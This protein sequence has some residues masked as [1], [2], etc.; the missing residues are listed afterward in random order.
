MTSPLALSFYRQSTVLLPAYNEANFLGAL[1]TAL[2]S[3]SAHVLVVDDGSTDG[4]TETA[5]RHGANVVRH[6]RNRGKGA[7]LRSGIEYALAGR[8]EWIAVMD[9]DGQHRPE[10][11]DCLMEQLGKEN[12]DLVFGQRA[13]NHGMPPLRRWT[14]R[15]MSAALR[16]LTGTQIIDSQCGLKIISRRAA[17]TMKLTSSHFEIESEI[18]IAAAKAGL[19]IATVPIETVYVQ[20]RRSHIRPLLDSLRWLSLIVRRVNQSPLSKRSSADSHSE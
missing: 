4:S 3:R 1:C 14:N 16:R 13:F 6:E 20:G 17:L 19:K 7:A 2:S 12:A 5:L 10:D 15:L 9:A 11:L 18:I 8:S